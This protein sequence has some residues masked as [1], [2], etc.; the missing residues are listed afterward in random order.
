M[1]MKST[2]RNFSS[3]IK[4]ISMYVYSTL[5]SVLLNCTGQKWGNYCIKKRNMF[6]FSFQY[7]YVNTGRIVM[8]SGWPLNV[9][10]KRL[11]HSYCTGSPN[12][13]TPSA[14][15]F[16]SCARELWLLINVKLIMLNITS[17]WTCISDIWCTLFKH[18]CGLPFGL[19]DS[20]QYFCQMLCLLS[21]QHLRDILHVNVIL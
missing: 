19:G 20:V 6:F 9:V 3:L 11:Y 7:L 12:N 8:F 15:V 17:T 21:L 10:F 1:G 5:Y 13:K 18:I 4:M 16:A 2:E 14:S